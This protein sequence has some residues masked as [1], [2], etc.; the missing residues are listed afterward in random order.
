VNRFEQLRCERELTQEQVAA[1]SGV[2]RG[3]VLRL[4]N[5][6]DPKPSHATA[7]ALADFY[8]ITVPALLG[9]DEQAA[10]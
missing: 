5:L 9:T 1:G 8:G 4:E 10:A 2:S 3:T 7:R 6:R